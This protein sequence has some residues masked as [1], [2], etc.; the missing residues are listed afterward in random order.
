MAQWGKIV[1]DIPGRTPARGSYQIT[2]ED[3]ITAIAVAIGEGDAL[4]SLQTIAQRWVHLHTTPRFAKEYPTLKS[5]FHAY[6]Q[7]VNPR[8]LEGGKRCPTLN[9]GDCS[10]KKVRRRAALLGATT[11]EELRALSPQDIRESKEEINKRVDQ[12]IDWLQGGYSAGRNEVP[13]AVHFAIHNRANPNTRKD[14]RRVIHRS[15]TQSFASVGSTDSWAS[16][17]VLVS[18]PVP[19]LFDWSGKSVAL[20]GISTVLGLGVVNFL[21]NFWGRK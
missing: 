4:E 19:S 12:A 11:I 20:I 16:D 3:G 7:P 8:F 21:L 2:D 15:G 13:G 6:N 10:P 17:A 18:P 9:Q 5:L 1:W 14:L